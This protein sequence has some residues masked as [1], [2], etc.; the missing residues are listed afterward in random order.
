MRN[1]FFSRN[2][3]AMELAHSVVKRRVDG[4]ITGRD[5]AEVGEERLGR[6]LQK[7]PCALEDGVD[8]QPGEE[9]AP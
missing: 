9:S 1:D 3:H 7:L 8:L 4:D 6:L 5:I 2:W